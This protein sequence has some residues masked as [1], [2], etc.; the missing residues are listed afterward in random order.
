LLAAALLLA[1]PAAAQT[2]AQLV[3]ATDI[4]CGLWSAQVATRQADS[5]ISG[6]FNTMRGLRLAEETSNVPARVGVTFGLSYR[7]L[8]PEGMRLR[9][10]DV[11]AVFE[12]PPGGLTNPSTGQTSASDE[13][14][15]TVNFGEARVEVYTFEE[16][17]EARPG[18]W[19]IRVLRGSRE[20]AACAFEVRP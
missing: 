13:K 9:T 16:P 20:L 5:T 4:K 8:R 11:R 12:Y 17:W 3:T 19:R 7:L 10:A 15:L 2:P 6:T 1:M 18:T 14:T